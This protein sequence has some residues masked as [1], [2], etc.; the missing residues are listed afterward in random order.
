MWVWAK[1]QSLQGLRYKYSHSNGS[2]ALGAT[3]DGTRSRRASLYGA[4]TG[5]GMGTIGTVAVVITPV[6]GHS[7]NDFKNQ[8]VTLLYAVDVTRIWITSVHTV[9]MDMD[10]WMGRS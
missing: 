1:I 10:S 4:V 5:L 8:S 3:A 7:W 9:A 2:S 6:Y